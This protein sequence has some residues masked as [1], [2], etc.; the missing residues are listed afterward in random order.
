MPKLRLHTFAMSLDGYGAGVDQDLEHPLGIGGRLLHEWA[1]ETATFGGSGTG[2]DD[3]FAARGEVDI[4]ATI[5]GRNMFGPIRGEWGDDRWRG[6]WGDNPPYHHDVFVLTHFPHEP[7]EMDGGT[8]FHFTDHD[9][10]TVL[11]RA[12]DAA[13]GLDVRLGGGV[14]TVRQYW[15]AGLID[16]AHI[17]IVPV[18]L[19]RGERVFD[20]LGDALDDYEVAEVVSS[21]AVTHVRIV[22]RG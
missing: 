21:P 3:D 13:G 17:P 15:R 5:M 7:I 22:K 10:E 20:D 2:I 19:G 6:W 8:T 18:L 9:I 1:F 14:S 4:G 12:F 16:E 11:K